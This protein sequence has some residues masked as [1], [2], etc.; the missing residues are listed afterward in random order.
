M[1]WVIP[2]A[3]PAATSVSRIASSSEV[4][5]WSTW[6][7][8]VTTGGRSTRSASASSYSGSSSTSSAAWTIS[9]FLS[10]P[11]ASV[12][13]ASSESVCVSVAISPSSISF[14]ITSGVPMPSDSATSLTVA[15]DWIGTG[16]ASTTTSS[17]GVRSGSTHG[18]RR[19]RPRPR[20]GGCCGG[21]GPCGRRDACES[22][23][24]RRRRPPAPPSRGGTG[25]VGRCCWPPA[26]SP[27]WP[28]CRAAGPDSCSGASCAVPVAPSP[29]SA[30]FEN[31]LAMSRSSTLE[32]AAFTSK[33]ACCRVARTSLLEIPR[34]L[35]ISWTRFFA[36]GRQILRGGGPLGGGRGALRIGRVGTGLGASRWRR[37]VGAVLA[38]L[39]WSGFRCGSRRLGIRRRGLGVL[40]GGRLLLARIRLAGRDGLDHFLGAAL[41]GLCG[42]VGCLARLL[43]GGRPRFHLIGVLAFERLVRGKSAVTRSGQ[44]CVRAPLAIGEDG[45]AA[46]GGVFV[47]VAQLG[48]FLSE[49]GLGADIDPPAGQPGGESCVLALLADGERELVV[50]HDDRGLLAVVV[51]EHFPHTRGRQRLGHEPRR[52]LVEGDDVDLLAAQL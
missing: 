29:P 44:G 42:G 2:P 47:V 6:P 20:R 49:L 3:S 52:L 24:T 41:R 46:P 7:M 4:L 51:D 38:R 16:G 40:A 25:R 1:C 30:P 11:S 13:M 45:C 31:A 18:V 8:T 5:P 21:G 39:D 17:L 37:R 28:P 34:S 35:A 43:L 10:N 23:T 48:L 14:L 22:I 12:T 9:T 50:G 36:T 15:P 26:P 33:P 27:G 32:A 19:R